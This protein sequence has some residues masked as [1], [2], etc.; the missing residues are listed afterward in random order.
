MA[1]L[2]VAD[3]KTY[4]AID[5]DG[6]DTEIGSLITAAAEYINQQTGKLYIGSTEIAND[7]LYQQC[8]KLLVAHWIENRGDQLPG[9]FTDMKHA[10]N[11]II[12]V[13]SNSSDYTKEPPAGSDSD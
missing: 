8:Q 12:R 6:L 9:S 1:A 7:A 3:I 13:I 10:V 11:S 2:T 5:N 4:L